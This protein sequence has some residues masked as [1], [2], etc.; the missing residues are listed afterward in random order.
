MALQVFGTNSIGLNTQAQLSTTDDALIV[1]GVT[2]ASTNGYAVFGAGDGH[3]VD[4]QGTVAG[5]LGAIWLGSTLAD[6]GQHVVIGENGYAATTSTVD[7]AVNVESTLSRVD[8]AGTIHGE[9]V[10]VRIGGVGSSN[11]SVIAN[12]GLIT[13]GTMAIQRFQGAVDILEVHNSGEISSPSLAFYSAGQATDRI[14]N[15]GLIAGDVWLGAGDD[16]VNNA[17]GRIAG[18]VLGES[19]MDQ[20][21]GGSFEDKFDGGGDIDLLSGGGGNDGLSGNTGDDFMFGGEG[22]DLLSGGA[23]SDHIDGDAGDDTAD[24]GTGADVMSGGAGNDFLHGHTDTDQIDGGAGNDTVDGGTGSDIVSGGADN[25]QINGGTDDDTLNGDAGNDTLNGETGKDTMSGGLGDDQLNGGADVDTLKGDAGND[26]LNGGAGADKMD[27]GAGDDSFIA[28]NAADVIVDT[29]GGID[30][31]VASFNFSL[32]DAAH[33]QGSVE[34][35]ALAGTGNING[36]GNALANTLTGNA[37]NNTLKAGAASDTVTGAAGNDSLF[38]EAGNDVLSG[39][40]GADKLYGGL[41]KDTMTGGAQADQFV[42]DTA[43]NTAANRDVVT[44]FVHGQDKFLLE[45]AVFAKVGAPGV[46]KAGA[47]HAGTAAH[48]A[49]DR[50]VYNKAT[51]VLS[52]DADGNGTLPAVQFALLTNKPVLTATDFAVM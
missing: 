50:I 26:T 15:S 22:N 10:G 11:R 13:G 39:G 8:N 2:V 34:K 1:S 42:F 14:F 52:Y 4:V 33:V 6:T 44:D 41:G 29:A 35:L 45:N 3:L 48:D 25:D 46:L 43:P 31:I 38:G 17:G 27:G 19:G 24:G 37:G 9:A 12:S 30:R 47:F 23:D 5:A 16:T 49:D 36:T 18:T 21:L 40:L 51:G 32:A 28:D 20:M 7:A